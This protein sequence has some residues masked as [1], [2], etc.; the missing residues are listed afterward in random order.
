MAI[1]GI[2]HVALKVRDLERSRAFYEL[3]EGC[4][5]LRLRLEPGT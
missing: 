3:L 5:L 4:L 2:N 1:T